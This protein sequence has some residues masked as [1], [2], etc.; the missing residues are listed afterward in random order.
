MPSASYNSSSGANAHRSSPH[1]S[2]SRS[3]SLRGS[4]PYDYSRAV[5]PPRCHAEQPRSR[6]TARS[7]QDYRSVSPLGS[8]RF[9]QPSPYTGQVRRSV[10]VSGPRETPRY[11][12]DGYY[13]SSVATKPFQGAGLPRSN[14]VR[15][16]D[17]DRGF[18]RAAYTGGGV[19][20]S[21][22]DYGRDSDRGFSARR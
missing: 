4:R 1:A 18:G 7:H 3:H 22:A 19:S 8:S 2:V 5:S 20:R 21:K 14:A 16:R 6:V 12:Q 15:S 9:E 13:G 11:G 17:N 10:T